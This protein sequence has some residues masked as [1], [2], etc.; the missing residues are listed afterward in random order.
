MSFPACVPLVSVVLVAGVV[1]I[2]V[3]W[4]GVLPAILPGDEIFNAER[5]AA[6]TMRTVVGW[7]QPPDV[8]PPPRLCNYGM[9]LLAVGAVLLA[10]GL[11]VRAS[12]TMI[13]ALLVRLARELR[14]VVF[15][16]A[17]GVLVTAGDSPFTTVLL[18]D[19]R[20]ARHRADLSLPLDPFFFDN[21][22]PRCAVHTRELLALGVDANANLDL[23]RR[24]IGHR[25]RCGTSRQLDRLLLRI[26]Q[27]ELRSAIG[28]EGCDEFWAG[29]ADV[30]LTSVPEVRC[31]ALL[32]DQPPSKMRLYRCEARPAIVIIGLAETGLEL[33]TRLCAQAQSPSH[34]PLLLVLVDTEAPA[35]A[36]E[37][38]ELWPAVSLVAALSPLALESRL[39]QSA[40]SLARHLVAERLI[41]TSVYIALD[42]PL[43]AAAWEREV[44]LAVRVVGQHS[45]LV[46][47]VA[48]ASGADAPPLLGEER[49]ELL[50]RQ[51][52]LNYL[53]RHEQQ[54][55]DPATEWARLP[56][57]LQEDN[58]SAAD[59]FWAKGRDLNIRIA[60][61]EGPSAAFA[62]ETALEALAAAEHRRWLASR[63]VSGWRFGEVYSLSDRT[64][65]SIKPWSELG[66]AQRDANRNVV[67]GI[68]GTLSAAGFRAQPLISF[69]IPRNGLAEDSIARLIDTA[70]ERVRAVN[71]ML[72]LVLAVED[73]RSF[74]LAQYLS[75]PPDLVLSLVLSQPL[76]GLALAAHLPESA[77]VQVA[78]RA[79]TVWLTNTDAVDELLAAW[80]PLGGQPA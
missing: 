38:R 42:D 36:R 10:I 14:L 58:R 74:R 4:W 37:L 9:M 44:S 7:A 78:Q 54:T 45:P 1:C 32:R 55:A 69:A 70:Q 18:E 67:R 33:L 13:S 47:N 76:V 51:L 15:S 19:A 59:H 40:V 49:L 71:G 41:P 25:R 39:P 72:Q 80:P 73:A 28:R 26:D 5:V 57:D 66:E 27:R 17:A 62:A 64:H 2:G 79:Q 48:Q 22:L 77:A 12:R 35:I 3:A 6:L 68:G 16:D 8:P 31:R 50:L 29:A 43:L 30:R 53:R 56:F 75:E 52:H 65:P 60:V 20:S 23:A 21:I 63:G 61:D 24:L 11:F 46:L 34:D